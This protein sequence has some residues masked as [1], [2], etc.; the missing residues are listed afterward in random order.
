MA[1]KRNNTNKRQNTKRQNTKRQ[2]QNQKSRNQRKQ[3]KKINTRKIRGGAFSLPAHYVI[4]YNNL[5]KGDVQ[6]DNIV[7]ARN[8]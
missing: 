6:R 1:N 3:N 4:P 2:R 5:D 7:E 8:E